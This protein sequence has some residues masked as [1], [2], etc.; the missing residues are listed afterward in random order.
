MISM[1]KK[2]DNK[3]MFRNVIMKREFNNNKY[4]RQSNVYMS[5]DEEIIADIY[6]YEYQY[7]KHNNKNNTNNISKSGYLQKQSRHLKIYRKRWIL[8]EN[9]LLFCFKEIPQNT[10]E[11]ENNYTE[12]FNLNNY[13]IKTV[14]TN[15]CEF[16]LVSKKTSETR[17]FMASSQ[18]EMLCWINTIQSAQKQAYNYDLIKIPVKVSHPNISFTVLSFHSPDI[19]WGYI[20]QKIIDVINEQCQPTT[21]DVKSAVIPEDNVT[22]HYE[23][24]V[25]HGG[26]YFCGRYFTCGSATDWERMCRTDIT[27][28]ESNFIQSEG[29]RMVTRK[30][31]QIQTNNIDCEYMIESDNDPFQCPIFSAMKNCYDFTQR[32]L[33][34]MEQ[35][36]HFHDE[37]KER[38][39]CKYGMQCKAFLRLENGGNKLYDRCHIKLY[40]HPPRTN[41]QIRMTENVDKLI[42]H[43]AH[44]QNRSISTQY[45][46]FN[47]ALSALINEVIEN[48]YKSDL[49]LSNTTDEQYKRNEYTIMQIV[50]EKMH[51]PRHKQLGLPLNKSQMLA[52]VLYTGCDCNYDLCKSHRNGDYKKWKYFDACLYKAISALNEKETGSY[53]LYTGLSNVKLPVKELKECYFPTYVSTSWIK[54]VAI[55]FIGDK[56]MIIEIH[57]D[58]RKRLKCCDVSW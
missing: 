37:Y 47:D 44:G 42:V 7:H 9:Q 55:T 50:D 13:H 34:H 51:H 48:G 19:K 22:K 27:E 8:L 38:S 53:K 10:V 18:R 30:V 20:I 17:L 56:G 49:F 54:N 16:Q 28:S 40:R 15:I 24:S 3:K 57:E 31:H 58:S 41:R 23:V 12:I 45:T 35:F 1:Q 46:G 29:I 26:R 39:A 36:T 14:T 21:F 5:F 33:S 11:K 4:S 25:Q 32:N 43:T 52:V 2:S 6:E